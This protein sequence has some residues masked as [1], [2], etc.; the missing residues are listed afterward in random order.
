MIS[1]H[2]RT[3]LRNL[4]FSIGLAATSVTFGASE[5]APSMSPL[6]QFESAALA[7]EIAKELNQNNFS[8][9]L[10]TALLNSARAEDGLAIKS[11]LAKYKKSAAVTFHGT[12]SLIHI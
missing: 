8:P 1:I 3:V 11:L 12:L 9:A 6:K 7:T 4:V 10:R 2:S 5:S